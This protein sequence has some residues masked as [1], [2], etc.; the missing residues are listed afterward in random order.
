MDWLKTHEYLAAWVSLPLMVVVALIQNL[1]GDGKGVGVP[2]MT[3]YFAFLI[4]LAVVFTPTFDDNSRIFAGFLC[5]PLLITVIYH[6]YVELMNTYPN[7]PKI[8]VVSPPN[9]YHIIFQQIQY[10]VPDFALDRGLGGVAGA[11]AP[12][13]LLALITG[14]KPG[15]STGPR[16]REAS[17]FTP[18]LKGEA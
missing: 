2:R 10:L 8:G 15:A 16:W 3:I 6:A 7:T 17:G 9:V 13:F 11:K 14:L 1:R 5:V 4:C 12:P 18:C